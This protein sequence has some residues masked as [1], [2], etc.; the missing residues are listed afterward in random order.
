MVAKKLHNLGGLT[1]IITVVIPTCPWYN[2]SP[3]IDLFS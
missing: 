2:K 3:N 1:L